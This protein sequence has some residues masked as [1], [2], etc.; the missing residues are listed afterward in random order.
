MVPATTTATGTGPGSDSITGKR[1]RI[2]AT[3]P[4]GIAASRAR[5]TVGVRLD[6]A[7]R[8]RTTARQ[9]PHVTVL[10]RPVTAR[11]HRGPVVVAVVRTAVGAV[12]LFM[13]AASPVAVVPMVGAVPT[14]GAAALI[15]A[16]AVVV[17]IMAAAEV[18]AAT[19]AGK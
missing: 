2:E 16:E 15:G 5:A 17:R 4:T 18:A 11:Q 12:S 6:T 19:M 13:A 10:R 1:R 14:M 8:Q 7:V 9:Q 3:A